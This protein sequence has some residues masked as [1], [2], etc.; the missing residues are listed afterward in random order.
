MKKT[1]PLYFIAAAAILVS[2]VFTA[3][4]KSA[5]VESPIGTQSVS[6][7]LTDALGVFDNVFID[8]K[9]VSLLID[10]SKDTRKKDTCNWDRIGSSR[11]E[12]KELSLGMA[13]LWG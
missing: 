6:F 1:N 7:Y 10:T 3:C 8:I 13:E 11:H 12:K 9:S 5:S 2:F 4:N